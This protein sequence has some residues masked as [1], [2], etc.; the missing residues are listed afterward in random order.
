[1]IPATVNIQAIIK[2]HPLVSNR[3]KELLSE[4]PRYE[5]KQKAIYAEAHARGQAWIRA[6]DSYSFKIA[7]LKSEKDSLLIGGPLWD[8]S[9]KG[10]ME[11]CA[12]IF[13]EAIYA[14]EAK[15]DNHS[16]E[17]KRLERYLESVNAQLSAPD[18]TVNVRQT[19]NILV[20]MGI[21]A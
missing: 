7:R 20:A 15:G 2:K 5:R 12:S 4:I 9:R 19:V 18:V 17:H 13:I 11:R 10:Y 8:E 14:L 3:L 16:A 6:E 21:F 1:M